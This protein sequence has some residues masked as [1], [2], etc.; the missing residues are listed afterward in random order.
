MFRDGKGTK[1]IETTK[2]KRKKTTQKRENRWKKGKNASENRI[3]H[4][5]TPILTRGLHFFRIFADMKVKEEKARYLYTMQE[6]Y[7]EL[8]KHISK[9]SR[10]NLI[11]VI[12]M[13]II[14]ISLL[15]K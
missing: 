7:D 13:W 15:L 11:L 5:K 14:T 3:S 2:E 8:M 4:Q 1:K 9:Q 12:W 10:M 6:V